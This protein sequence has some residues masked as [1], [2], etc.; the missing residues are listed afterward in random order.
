MLRRYIANSTKF[1][2][3]IIV[4]SIPIGICK[5][6]MEIPLARSF[7]INVI[8]INLIVLITFWCILMVFLCI[9]NTHFKIGN[10]IFFIIANN[11]VV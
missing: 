8:Q 6:K 1:Q 11:N 4:G 10:R 2:P 7:Y 3:R 5:I 9:T